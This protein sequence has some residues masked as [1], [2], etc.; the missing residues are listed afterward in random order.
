VQSEWFE[1]FFQG[2]AVEFWARAMPPAVTTADCDFLETGL[3]LEPGARVLDVP[4]GNGRHSIELARRGYRC[5]GV[6]LSP[7]FLS[8]AAESAR[9]SVVQATFVRG[10]MR[11]LDQAVGLY[12]EFDG[13]FCFGNSF[14]YLNYANATAFLAALA[15][16]LRKGGRLAI[17]T[18]TAAEAMMPPGLPRQRWHRMGDIVM[19]SECRY[20]AAESRLDIDYTFIQGERTE[21]QSTASYVF[22]AAEYRRM[23]EQAGFDILAVNGGVAGEAFAT[24]PGWLVLTARR[25]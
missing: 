10:D 19:L 16:A 20:A 2:A 5:T 8:L 24:G 9:S 3:A 4:C 6:D 1:T 14:C 13:A 25:R 15:R 7:E 21:T 11:T 12:G 18:G 17:Q 23:I 22:T